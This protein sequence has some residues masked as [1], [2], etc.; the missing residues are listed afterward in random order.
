MGG[1]LWLA[2]GHESDWL[3]WTASERL[4]RLAWLM[5]LAALTY[6][7]TLFIMGFRLRDFQRKA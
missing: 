1:V 3:R 7:A 4:F 6:F 2:G 5:P